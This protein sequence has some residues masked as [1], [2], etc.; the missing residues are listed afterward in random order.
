[1]DSP[2]VI[3]PL[4][5]DDLGAVAAIFGHYV[6]TSCATFEQ[7]PPS[8]EAWRAKSA[9]IAARGLPFLVAE[10]ADRILGFAYGTAWR[11]PPSYLHT[12]EESIYLVPDAVGR[13]LGR[14]LLGR[15]MEEA[16]ASGIHQL[17]AVIADTGNPASPHLHRSL[18]FVEV[19]RLRR[20]GF[21]H[22]RWLDTAL[23]QLELVPVDPDAD[24]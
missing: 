5:L 12:A 21:K 24:D 3:R 10:S 1:V 14:Q 13:G 18:G 4:E 16:A 8:V 2:T 7:V 11:S 23:Y 22:G 19:G 17:L 6:R 20:V 9:D 15:L